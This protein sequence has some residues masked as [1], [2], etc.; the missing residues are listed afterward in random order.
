MSLFSLP[1]WTQSLKR[2]LSQLSGRGR[3]RLP[4][5]RPSLSDMASLPVERL[6]R[7]VQESAVALKYLRLLGPIDWSR[8]PERPDRR[9]WPDFPPVPLAAFAAACLVKIDQHQIYMSNLRQYLVEHPALLWVLGFP[10][11]ASD[12]FPW[13]FD[14]DASL[15]TQRHFCRLLWEMP[16]SAL[17]FLLDETVR[18]ICAELRSEVQ[19]V[20]QCV[21]VDTKHVIAWVKENNAKAYFEGPRYDKTQQPAGDPDCKLGCKRTHNQSKKKAPLEGIPTPHKNPVPA[22]ERDFGEFYWGYGSG[23]VATKVD[24]WVEFILAELTQ[25]F[26]HADVSYFFPL[27]AATERRLGFRP[28]FGALDAAF[29]AFYTY[30]YFHLAGGFAA[31][32]LVEKGKGKGR[33]FSED[34]LP[35]CAAGLPMPLKSTYLDRTSTIIEH[36]RGQYVC[37]LHFPQS[38]GELCPKNDPHWAKGGCRTTVA[39][40]IGARLRHQI[41]RQGE[42]YKEVYRQ[43]TADERVNSQAKAFGIERPKLR[44]QASI[45]NLNTLIY[46]LINLH[47]LQRVRQRRAVLSNAAERLEQK[48]TA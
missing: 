28:K 33:V 9:I 32:P 1:H 10:L 42:A 11:V 37:P 3:T 24:E 44:N 18:L 43:R 26:D 25:P 13:G 14:A 30:E 15:P 6:P 17:Q 48:Q 20:G 35:L 21:S 7:L 41:D 4:L 31:V 29:D 23:V 12:R 27:M 36:E 39:T 46:V 5:K 2:P 16:N 34:G 40:S 45:T 19:G 8:F 47:A 38:T 22:K